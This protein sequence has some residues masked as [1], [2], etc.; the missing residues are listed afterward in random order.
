MQL[1]HRR[2]AAREL[3]HLGDR[4]RQITLEHGVGLIVNDRIDVALATNADGVHLPSAGMD[5][6]RARQLVGPDL[7]LGRSVHSINEIR[8]LVGTGLDYLQYGPVYTTP[9]K[10]AYGPPHGEEHF[11][12][13][14]EAAG[15]TPVVAVGGIDAERAARLAALGAAGVAVIRAVARAEDPTT[16]TRN[17]LCALAASGGVI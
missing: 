12:E 2:L 11:K 14:L 10:A 1:R 4:L 13:A 17:L 8:S 9:S 15:T 7:A 5:V 3:K 6:D 16:A